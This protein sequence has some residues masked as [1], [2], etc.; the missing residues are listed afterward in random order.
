MIT[1]RANFR[2]QSVSPPV[3]L[4]LPEITGV[5]TPISLVLH[6]ISLFQ[7]LNRRRSAHYT[8]NVDQFVRFLNE[9]K[10]LNVMI[11]VILLDFMLNILDNV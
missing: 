6:L 2:S 4:S 7:I 10:W 9:I 8:R 3:H 1:T 5:K 11:V